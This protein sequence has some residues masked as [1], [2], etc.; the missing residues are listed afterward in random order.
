MD[1]KFVIWVIFAAIQVSDTLSLY[2]EN[3]LLCE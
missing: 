2:L 3:S 1:P